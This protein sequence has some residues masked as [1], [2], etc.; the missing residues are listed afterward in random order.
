MHLFGQGFSLIGQN[1][2]LIPHNLDHFS[3]KWNPMAILS[4]YC[5]NIYLQ[6]LNKLELAS[7]GHHHVGTTLNPNSTNLL[8]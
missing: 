5:Q 3:F 1:F 8:A 7:I 6:E 2:R 4:T